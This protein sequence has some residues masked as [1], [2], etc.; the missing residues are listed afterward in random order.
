MNVGPGFRR[1]SDQLGPVRGAYRRPAAALPQARG[2]L[3]ES[4][5]S[6]SGSCRSPAAGLREVYGR[7]IR[8]AAAA[9]GTAG[10]LPQVR[11][12]LPESYRR[13]GCRR[14]VFTY[15]RSVFACRRPPG[16]LQE[17]CRRPTAAAPV[18]GGC[19]G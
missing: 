1:V 13:E 14:P 15:G 11:F 2:G 9:E 12:R 8:A 16:G 19:P 7:S 5:R 18:R 3:W 17:A 10:G 4:C 6:H